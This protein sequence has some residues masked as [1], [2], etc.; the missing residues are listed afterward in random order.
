[1]LDLHDFPSLARWFSY[2]IIKSNEDSISVHCISNCIQWN[3]SSSI[4]I[5]IYTIIEHWSIDVSSVYIDGNILNAL[6]D[7]RFVTS[8][9]NIR[10]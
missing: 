9:F 8:E 1:M 2:G 7:T 3:I 5:I 10:H 4:Q 6:V